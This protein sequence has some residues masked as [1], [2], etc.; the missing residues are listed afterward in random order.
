MS[1]NEVAASIK[2]D[3]LLDVYIKEFHAS[4]IHPEMK[5]VIT[6]IEQQQEF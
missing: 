2:F 3:M 1:V 6:A 4:E 5:R